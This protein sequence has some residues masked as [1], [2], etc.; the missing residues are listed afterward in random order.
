MESWAPPS[1]SQLEAEEQ[2][3]KMMLWVS[4]VWGSGFGGRVGDSPKTKN[5]K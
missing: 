5:E 4:L 3:R 1:L 2:R